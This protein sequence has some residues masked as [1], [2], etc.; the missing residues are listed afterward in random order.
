MRKSLLGK[1]TGVLSCI[2]I[3]NFGAEP[4]SLFLPRLPSFGYHHHLLILTFIFQYISLIIP[5]IF[6]RIPEFLSV[7]KNGRK[8]TAHE[9]RKKERKIV[10]LKDKRENLFSIRLTFRDSIYTFLTLLHTLYSL[11]SAKIF[12]TKLH[13]ISVGKRE[14]IKGERKTRRIRSSFWLEP[15]Q[16]E[17]TISPLLP[18]NHDPSRL[19]ESTSSCKERSTR[20][21]RADPFEA[22]TRLNK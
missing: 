4:F 8:V 10:D 1:N 13:A 12:L 3:M 19:S 15:H 18:L 16:E 9:A 17:I 6:F 20:I 22:R 11:F 7:Q 14:E 2:S 5:I 21:N